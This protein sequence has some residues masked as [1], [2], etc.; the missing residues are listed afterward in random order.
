MKYYVIVVS[1]D[2]VEKGVEG[3]F[4]QAGHGKKNLLEKL[5]KHDWI[6]YYSS[7]VKYDVDKPYQKFTAAGQVYDDK[8]YQ[9]QVNEN[10]KP[11]RRKVKYS[12]IEELEIKPLIQQLSFIKN[13]KNWGLHL[14]AGFIEI[15]K[16]DFELIVKKML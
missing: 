9:T 6:I 15:N 13:K 3:G 12:D 5:K 1:K 16:S 11:W 2:H 10:F 14:R 8:P 4:A 7:K